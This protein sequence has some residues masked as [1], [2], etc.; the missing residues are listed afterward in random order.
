MRHG[1]V[2]DDHQQREDEEEEENRKI[3]VVVVALQEEDRRCWEKFQGY[4]AAR[5]RQSA[6]L[7]FVGQVMHCKK[8][9]WLGVWQTVKSIAGRNLH[10][11]MDGWNVQG[12]S[13]A[14]PDSKV[15]GTIESHADDVAQVVAMVSATSGRPPVLVAHSFGGL[16]AMKALQM[17]TE[18]SPVAGLALLSSVP[19]S[20]NDG[21]V[22]RFLSSQPIWALRVGGVAAAAIKMMMMNVFFSPSSSRKPAIQALDVA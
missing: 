18:G 16:I 15:A 6:A 17:T 21:I 10:G 11:W 8:E 4:F 2:V 5:G 1:K 14:R 19:P 3:V 13:D 12:E 22:K 7:S 20:G 9:N